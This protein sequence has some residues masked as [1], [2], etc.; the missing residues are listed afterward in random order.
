MYVPWGPGSPPRHSRAGLL[1]FRAV[2][3][4][5]AA[6]GHLHHLEPDARDVADRVT[7]A[8][9]A[10]DEDF[11]IFV[12]EVQAAVPWYEG[13]DLLAVLD[14][15]DAAAL[16][17]GRV[18]LLGLN[19]NLLN[20]DTLSVGSSAERIALVL[21]AEV[22]LLVVLVG[23]QL[24]AAADRQLPGRPDSARLAGAHDAGGGR[25]LPAD[26]TWS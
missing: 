3:R 14:E 4:A 8:A 20:D 23:P 22:G 6:S 2:Q 18:G 21:R 16:A 24:R 1:L 17:D 11:V 10:R 12:D 9:E 19:P 5:E 26:S 15:L 25:K 7:A 13:R